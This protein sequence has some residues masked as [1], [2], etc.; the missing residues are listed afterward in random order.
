MT[1]LNQ[2]NVINSR[3][4]AALCLGF[5]S[6][7]PLAL[8]SSTLQAWFT[9]SGINLLTIGF[10]SFVGL[11][12]VLKFMWAPLM[13]HFFIPR[14]GRRR[15]WVLLTQFAVALALF[16]LA[17]MQPNT[18]T[19]SMLWMALLVAFLAASQDVSIDAYRTDLLLP[20][21][22][23]LGAAYFVFA[24]RVATLV[25]GG[26]A[27]LCAQYLGWKITYQIMALIM[28]LS[29][30][31]TYIAPTLVEPKPLPNLLQ[32]INAALRDLLRRDNIVITLFFICL[33]KFGCALAM[34]LNT[35]FLLRGLGFSLAEVGV[36]SKSVIFLAVVLGAFVGGL[37]LTKWNLYR[38]LII[39]GFLQA[40]AI[41]AFAV[42]AFSYQ[43][44]MIDA[45]Q[46]FMLMAVAL[47]LENFFSGM[48]TAA[49]FAFL[50]SLCQQRYSATQ[51]ALFSA[52]DALPRVVLG[53]LAAVL[54]TQVGWT[55]FYIWAFLLSFPG[56]VLL[57]FLKQKVLYGEHATAS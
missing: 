5:S 52:L 55:E 2:Q 31:P 51:Y 43:A 11:P 12:Y 49:F 16:A 54:V 19:Q 37:M 56:L 10:V 40:V 33:Y 14:L 17:T 41:L 57:M 39:F 32:N 24:F 13:D 22:R 34:S 7:L 42:L 27:L 23:G 15:G 38:G 29:M 25:S 3:L 45:T 1:S 9:E 30:F 46:K 26:L 20:K 50:M 35:T 28:L 21:E 18:Q 53:P 6:G 4:F 47:F 48:G 8:T 36:A 44:M